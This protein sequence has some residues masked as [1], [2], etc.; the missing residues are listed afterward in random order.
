MAFEVFCFGEAAS[1]HGTL[2]Q[3]HDAVQSAVERRYSSDPQRWKGDGG[4][5]GGGGAS[6]Q[7]SFVAERVRRTEGRM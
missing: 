4:G 2:S 3:D 5:R 1:T 6:L 7:Q